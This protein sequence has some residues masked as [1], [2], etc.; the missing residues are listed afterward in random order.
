MPTSIRL[1]F[2]GQGTPSTRPVCTCPSSPGS[3]VADRRLGAA[4]RWIERA[5]ED[6]LDDGLQAPR[7]GRACGNPP[8]CGIAMSPEP[9]NWL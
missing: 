7:L 2:E 5:S 9:L 6:Q 1:A 8:T 4:P 3:G